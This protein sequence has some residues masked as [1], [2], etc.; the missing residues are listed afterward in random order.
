[1]ITRIRFDDMD[2]ILL[3]WTTEKVLVNAGSNI[4]SRMTIPRRGAPS[5]YNRRRG[6]CFLLSPQLQWLTSK[7]YH[8]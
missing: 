3:C 7:N 8:P 2:K 4:S 5:F 6:A 1:M